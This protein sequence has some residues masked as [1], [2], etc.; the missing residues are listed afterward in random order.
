[1]AVGKVTKQAVDALKP[2]AGDEFLWDTTLKG[3]GVRVAKNGEK[4]YVV[5]Y[6]TPGG[7]AGAARRIKIGKHGSPW[8][9]ETAR[10]HAKSLLGQAGIGADPAA[11]L[12]ELRAAITV[13][14]LCDRYLKEGPV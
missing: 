6:R 3:F 14:Q 9:A 7:R 2:G 4:S 1:M 12:R 5:Q 11:K 13:D 8:T 10:Q